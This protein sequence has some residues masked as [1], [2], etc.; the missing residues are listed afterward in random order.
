MCEMLAYPPLL[1]AN[2]IICFLNVTITCIVVMTIRMPLN[3]N[4]THIQGLTNLAEI[5]LSRNHIRRL[6]KST[7]YDTTRLRKVLLNNN[8]LRSLHTKVLL[9]L[10]LYSR[11]VIYMLSLSLCPPPH[12]SP[13]SILSHL[14]H[15]V[16]L[17]SPSPLYPV[18]LVSSCCLV[19][20]PLSPPVS[21]ISH[22]SSCL[23]CLILSPLSP[24]VSPCLPCLLLSPPSPYVSSCH[25][26]LV[27]T[28]LPCL[29]LSPVS[30]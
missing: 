23:P 7:F 3:T 30:P 27:S 5:D 2:K 1:V 29:L 9:C 24:P 16:S 18:S 21:S 13:V 26:S 11:C 10:C 17:V 19:L 12:I 4:A 14:S 25:V 6:A 15:P 20:A 22:V 28:C 8:R